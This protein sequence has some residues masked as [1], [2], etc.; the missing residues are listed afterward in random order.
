MTALPT[1]AAPDPVFAAFVGA[2]LWP[3]L[4]KRA[5]AELPGAGITS[6]DD[7]TVAK[8]L[9]MPRVGKQR[10][11]RLFS[12]FLSA[13]P[14]YDVVELLVRAGLEAKLASSAADALGDDAARRLRD[15]PWALL[16]LHGVTL[17]D[18]DRLAISLLPGADRQDS[19]RGRAI[20]VMTLRTATRDGHTVLPADLVVAALRAQGVADPAAAIV[21]AVDSGEVLDHEPP[22]PEFDEDAG[23]G[24]DGTA[25]PPGPDPA[26]RMLSLGRFGMAEDAV[27]EG[28]ARLAATAERIADPAAVRSVAKGL[29]EA[30]KQSVAQVLGAGVSL[31]TGG[32]GT[33]KSRTVAAVVELLVAKG[34][35]VA[36]AAPTGRAAKRLEELTGH[37]AVTVHRLLQA[38]GFGGGF[39]RNEEWPLDADVVVVDEASML[40]VELTAALLE[41]CP[42]GTHLLLVGD[43]AQLPSIGPGHVLGDLIDSGVVPVTELTTLYRQAEGG[44]IARLASAV[45]TGELPPV[46]SP[47]REVVVVPAAGSGEAARR[48]VQLV[49]DSI[50]RA[51]RIDPRNVQVVTP[52]HRGPAGT[53]ELN[54]ALKER[55]NPGEGTVFGFDVGDRVVATANHLDLEP[56]G[57]ANGEVGTVTGTGEGSLTVDFSSGPVTVT[58]D[59]LPDLKH[60]WAITVHRAQGSEWP[61]VVVVL[62]PEAGGMLSRPL[63]Y[64]ALTRAQQHLS[65]VHAS[66]AALARA[67]REVDVRPRR[68]R[69]AAL[70]RE[71]LET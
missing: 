55:L 35:E 24:D 27:A 62:P 8:L 66:G 69:L 45:R 30:Q 31:L 7:V 67:V 36:L 59:A 65:I 39:A 68:T 32:P 33:G 20:V 23:G 18:A 29:D 58:G 19:R 21:A 5:V 47:D 13:Q 16:G 42:D 56:I 28:V 61:G 52:V 60:G 38:Q 51:L 15:D 26:L 40:D 48:V 34:T 3:G 44:A 43:P 64:T 54:K 12:S 14:T 57:F 4:G 71:N 10:A 11:E 41:A 1:P 53:I 6:P 17:T 9:K 70:L 37:P 50:P 49:T 25:E 63:V 22:E 2:G 46:D